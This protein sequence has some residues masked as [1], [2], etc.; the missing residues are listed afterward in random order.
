MTNYDFDNLTLDLAHHIL[1]HRTTIRATAKVFNMAKSTVHNILN[2]RLK[3]LNY[4]LYCEVKKLLEE[5][6]SVKHIHGGQATKLKY[7]KLKNEINT[8]DEKE[9]SI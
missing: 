3:I 6:F 8:Y 5:N 4:S 7:E 2:T 9:F 1:E